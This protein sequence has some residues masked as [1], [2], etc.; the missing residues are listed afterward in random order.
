MRCGPP[1]SGAAIGDCYG[2]ETHTVPPLLVSDARIEPGIR[3][4]HH[5]VQQDVD[6]RGHE[7]HPLDQEIVLVENCVDSEMPDAL[8]CEHRLDDDGAA[9]QSTGLEADQ[10]HDRNHCRFEHVP[11][12]DDVPA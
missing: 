5:Q 11:I 9:E 10:R 6:D 8:P 1:T 7:H 2:A 4:V 12:Q 3:Y